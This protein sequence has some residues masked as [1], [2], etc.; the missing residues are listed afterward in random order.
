MIAPCLQGQ[1]PAYRST[2][3]LSSECTVTRRSTDRIASS[4]FANTTSPCAQRRSGGRWCLRSL[5]CQALTTCLLVVIGLATISMNKFGS[6]SR[7]PPPSPRSLD[8]DGATHRHWSSARSTGWRLQRHRADHVF[9]G[10]PVP[11]A[12]DLLIRP[13]AD[14]RLSAV[15]GTQRAAILRALESPL[16]MSDRAQRM[17]TTAST[18]TFHCNH[19][20]AARLIQR[21]RQ[22]NRVNVHVTSQGRE[23]VAL[24]VT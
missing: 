5:G 8:S 11:A 23:L 12:V 9:L 4:A 2:R 22:S 17:G 20:E 13:P 15:L 3:P 18:M 21:R 24:M 16:P 7:T 14:D 1:N 10:Y 19:L 6:I